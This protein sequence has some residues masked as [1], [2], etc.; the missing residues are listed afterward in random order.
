[1]MSGGSV[2]VETATNKLLKWSIR[3]PYTWP[4][5][6]FDKGSQVSQYSNK[7][8]WVN[9]LWSL[10][11]TKSNS[12]IPA[13]DLFIIYCIFSMNTI[14]ILNYQTIFPF[15]GFFLDVAM[16][17]Y[18]SDL[19]LS[20]FLSLSLSFIAYY[21]FLLLLLP[22]LSHEILIFIITFRVWVFNL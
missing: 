13:A 14:F 15:T 8:L 10:Q 4:P 7:L 17:R 22:F 21:F 12:V 16:M 3:V 1:M 18:N 2:S 9:V 11:S 5:G 6:C 20:L 19:S